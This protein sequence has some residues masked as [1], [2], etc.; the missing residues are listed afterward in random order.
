MK[1]DF[2]KQQFTDLSTLPGKIAIAGSDED[3]SWSELK[4]EVEVLSAEFKNLN[5]PQGHPVIIYGH[6][7]YLF[8]VAILACIHS[9]TTYIPID[10]IYPVDR[11]K[12]IIE[13]TGAQIMINCT[14]TDPEF[15][16]PVVISN[17][18][19]SSIHS[20]PDY[21]D[22]IY[23]NAEDPLQYIMFTSGST[24]E[25][26]GVQITRNSILTF[27]DWASKDFGFDQ[28]DVFMNQAP[29]TFD[30]SL[31][32]VLNSF[33]HGGTLVLNST[34]TV[35]DQQAFLTRILNYKC[36]VWT[37]TPSF[38]FLFLRHPEFKKEKNS[39]LKTFLFMGEELPNRTCS[40]LRTNFYSSR[41]LNAYGPTEATIVTT[42]V[43]ITD[44]V[45]KQYPSL[46]IGY[47]M[48][49]SELLIEKTDPS[50]KEGELVI[51]GDHVS[52]GY[53]K[54]EEY[55]RQKFFMHNGKRA[56]KT[57]DLAYYENGMVFYLGRND[58]Q[59]KMHGFR[60]ELNEISNVICRQNNIA[61]A[62]TVPLKRNNEVKKIIS[63][64]TVKDSIPQDKLKSE[65]IPFLEKALPYYMIPGD[66]I[67][68]DEFPHSVS[69]KIDKNRLIDNYIKA[70]TGTV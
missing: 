20:T 30:V 66:I 16:M 70:Q 51:V 15:E 50:V 54:H 14:D 41:I 12:K 53:F 43:E 57:G 11:V 38:A 39:F 32:D 46:P 69:H 10:K 55:N 37:S 27:I 7:E 4:E 26:K 58:D 25:P 61:D 8:P 48:P 1:Y 3:L 19:K 24:G 23:N 2:H 35:K 29:F 44:E 62:V 6:K 60:I 52:I 21:Q 64:V 33:V 36:T 68:V 47:P 42:L 17:E 34:E 28:D 22:R 13:K 9:G 65:L 18:L 59:V 67:I 40:I 49:T 5:I 45:I 56:F 31:C 63:F